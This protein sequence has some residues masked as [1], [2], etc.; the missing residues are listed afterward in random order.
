MPNPHSMPIS[1]LQQS[2]TEFIVALVGVLVVSSGALL[3]FRRV[4][5]ERPAVGTFNGRDITILLALII[6]LPFLYAALPSWAITCVLALTFCAALSIG[7]RLVWGAGPVW[8]GIG[9]LIGAN[10]WTSH[11]L[12]GTTAG[13]ELWWVELDIMVALGAIAV[14]NLYVQGG[15]K[16]KHVAWF[17]LLLALYDAGSTLVVNVT[18]VLVE[19]FIGHPLDPT[20]GIRGGVN[21]YG[22]G[23]GDLL[24]Y[25]LFVVASYKAYGKAAARLA[26]G[27]MVVFGAAAPSLF[28]L[29]HDL[30]DFRNDVVIPSQLFFAPAAFVCYLWMRHR[31]GRERTM[32]EYRASTGNAAPAPVPAQAA[33]APEPASV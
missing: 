15:M 23:I 20:W 10:I 11:T 2:M 22:I 3:Y 5:Q 25:A 30:V 13:W 9:L 16:L 32:A 4:R 21:N 17:G 24:F 18:A 19:D 7:Y 33:P 29:I 6:G 1:L 26:F 28:P 8:L 31:Y 12:M 27:V 14:A